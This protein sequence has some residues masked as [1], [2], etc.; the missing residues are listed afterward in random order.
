M[1]KKLTSCFPGRAQLEGKSYY[2]FWWSIIPVCG[3]KYK[4]R[5]GLSYHYNHTHKEKPPTDLQG[6]G[7]ASLDQ[8]GVEGEPGS[9]ASSVGG[10]P[11]PTPG[12]DAGGSIGSGTDLATTVASAGVKPA[13]SNYIIAAFLIFIQGTIH[14]PSF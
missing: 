5:P 2:L 4:T 7:G 11:P 10:T 3:A 9:G 8:G 14:L 12:Q 6:Q 13:K 1:K